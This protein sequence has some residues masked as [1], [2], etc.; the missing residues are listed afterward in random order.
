MTCEGGVIA[1][2]ADDLCHRAVFTAENW[3]SST[4]SYVD[5][6]AKAHLKRSGP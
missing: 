3:I 6:S 2:R 4:E 1:L 5:V